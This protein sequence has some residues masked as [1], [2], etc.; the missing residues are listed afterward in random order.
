MS[1]LRKYTSPT[2]TLEILG[3]SSALSP[4]AGQP[5]IKNIQFRLQLEGQEQS[6]EKHREIRG[7]R[8]QLEALRLAVESYVQG[9]LTQ[10]HDLIN[11]QT[12]SRLKT[13]NSSLKT[14]ETQPKNKANSKNKKSRKAIYLQAKGMK[15]HELFMGNKLSTT[16]RSSVIHLSTLQLFDLVTV[17]DEYVLDAIAFPALE[18][19]PSLLFS[20]SFRV[21]ASITIA[22]GLTAYSLQLLNKFYSSQP[23]S[24]TTVGQKI[25]PPES[26]EIAIP[27][28]PPMPSPSQADTMPSEEVNAEIQTPLTTT[29][30]V[31]SPPSPI[32]P[33]PPIA[34][35]DASIA[36]RQRA[37]APPP[38]PPQ[39]SLKRDVAVEPLP[40][41]ETDSGAIASNPPIN[42]PPVELR[43]TPA[44][45]TE[46]IKDIPQV[47]EVK[48]YFQKRWDPPE[49]LDISI[50]YRLA[51]ARDGTV[52]QVTPLSVAA[53]N[54]LDRTKMPL[55]GEEFVSPIE[56]ELQ[57]TIRVV[58]NPNG[59]VQTFLESL[60]N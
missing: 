47:A 25:S 21:A 20:D 34:A 36:R 49:T 11:A 43:N 22:L 31:P 19:K 7:D 28:S 5:V 59:T 35:D 40:P 50:E 27:T 44:T 8:A 10:S 58:L 42:K 53:E 30:S 51:I 16:S 9:L 38:P 56:G 48:A 60:G 4:W 54:Y 41:A 24:I 14:G 29:P 1:V 26:Q 15:N 13:A 2:C 3:K 45:D 37:I 6:A 57:P 33:L 23:P 32:V 46:D 55:W 52:K 39:I 12:L 17:M 18:K